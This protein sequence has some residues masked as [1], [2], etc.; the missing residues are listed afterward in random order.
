M[1]ND[2]DFV[3]CSIKMGGL[4]L[5]GVKYSSKKDSMQ[6]QRMVASEKYG[7]IRQTL[8]LV[9]VPSKWNGQLIR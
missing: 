8:P 4:D 6:L 5:Q 1:P 7:V 2:P 9:D 3:Q